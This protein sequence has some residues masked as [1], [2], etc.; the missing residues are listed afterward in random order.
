MWLVI[1]AY[2]TNRGGLWRLKV[3]WIMYQIPKSLQKA[4]MEKKL[5]EHK[6]VDHS[7]IKASLARGENQSKYGVLWTVDSGTPWEDQM[8]S[9]MCSWRSVCRQNSPPPLFHIINIHWAHT[10]SCSIS[11]LGKEAGNEDI[12]KIEL[13]VVVVQDYFDYWLRL[14]LDFQYISPI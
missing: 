12:C 3:G 7:H 6:G 9:S 8:I 1:L 4:R 13:F 2:S 10:I 5:S 14:G 11:S